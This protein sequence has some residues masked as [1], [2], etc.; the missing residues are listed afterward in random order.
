MDEND[1]GP[2]KIIRI[3]IYY[4]DHYEHIFFYIYFIFH[5]PLQAICDC[6]ERKDDTKR[7][8]ALPLQLCEME[9]R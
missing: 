6:A 2:Y 3:F 1:N 8:N 7:S 9:A 4:Y 5:S